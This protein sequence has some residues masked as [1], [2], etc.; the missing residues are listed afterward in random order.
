MGRVIIVMP[1]RWDDKRKCF[2]PGEIARIRRLRKRLY[3]AGYRPTKV[4]SAPTESCILTALVLSGKAP[5]I[6]L[7]LREIRPRVDLSWRKLEEMSFSNE[8]LRNI[9]RR[10]CEK[11]AEKLFKVAKSSSGDV[12]VV[13]YQVTGILLVLIGMKDWNRNIWRKVRFKELGRLV[14]APGETKLEIMEI[15]RS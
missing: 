14:C 3:G 1:G 5:Q 10:K 6:L 7:C 8:K 11:I 4:Y 15:F 9:L 13:T 12:L 2:K